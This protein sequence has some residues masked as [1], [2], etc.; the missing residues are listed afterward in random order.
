MDD[1]DQTV[2]IGR[3]AGGDPPAGQWADHRF[4]DVDA[5]GGPGADGATGLASLSFIVASIRRRARFCCLAAVFGLLLG[6]G[7]FLLHPPAYQATTTTLLALGP[8]ED[9]QTAVQ[10]DAALAMSRPVAARARQQLRISDS[11]SGLL[12][13]Y[14]ASSVTSRVLLITVRASSASQAVSRA[15]AVTAAFLQYRADQLRA[16]SQIA[17][18]SLAQPVSAGKAHIASLETKISNLSGQTL[19]ASQSTRLAGLRDVLTKDKSTQAALEEN[20][21][22]Q[23]QTTVAGTYTAIRGSRVVNNAAL[24]QHSRK[25]TAVI[26]AATGLVGFTIL[27]VGL[28]VV[29]ALVSDKLRRR[30]DIALALGTP[31]RVSVGQVRLRRLLPGRRGLAAASLPAV[32]RIAGQLRT[33]LPA[34]PG[35]ATLAVIPADRTDVAAL[36]IVALAASCAK[37]GQRVIV[38]DL[39]PGAPA[40]RVLGVKRPGIHQVDMPDAQLTV[41]LPERSDLIPVGP[42][43]LRGRPVPA[44]ARRPAANGSA[45]ADQAAAEVPAADQPAGPVTGKPS[46]V[47]GP[48]TSAAADLATAYASADVLLT[49]AVLDPMIGA[50]HL[51]TWSSN[52]VAVVTAGRSSWTR[53]QAV[54][55]MIRLAGIRL[56]SAVLIGAEQTDESLGMMH[57]PR[58][59]RDDGGFQRNIYPAGDAHFARINGSS[60]NAGD[61]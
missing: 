45:A 11:V 39:C 51:A 9:P 54:G 14:T 23:Q 47:N 30:D 24:V 6:S 48:G 7:L 8:S 3:L 41:V 50:E 21:R 19:T 13:S 27:G 55:E 16:Y 52:A 2:I 20:M 31:V 12:A 58:A 37:E 15:R 25:K 43:R 1:S 34:D 5:Q 38:A 33:I 29:L 28:T 61:K 59:D 17:S 35:C 32:Q 46:C 18:N 53:T 4:G 56:V 22:Q 60:D 10:T 42:L 44:A 40:G 49:L 26:Y 36:A 57:P